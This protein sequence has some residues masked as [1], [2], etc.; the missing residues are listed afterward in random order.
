MSEIVLHSLV[1]A[2][3]VLLAASVVIALFRI[4][5]GPSILDRMIGT[6]VVLAA[7][8]CGLGGYMALSD[9]TDLLPVLIV[10][11]MLG[12]V[13]SV[14]VSRY[15]SKSDSM[16]PGAEAGA[17][18]EF[19]A[20][21]WHMPRDAEESS[22]GSTSVPQARPSDDVTEIA[23]PTYDAHADS[24][25]EGEGTGPDPGP[26]DAEH[27]SDGDGQESNRGS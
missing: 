27:V 5:R 17:L 9:R 24:G 7:I 20:S 10:L 8:M 21:D 16:T 19:S 23:D 6:D 14:S 15:V 3:S 13:G 11:A 18:S 25:G 12:F 26:D 1:I 4:V 2:G 22:P